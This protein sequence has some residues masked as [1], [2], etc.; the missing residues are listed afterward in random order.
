MLKISPTSEH[1][2]IGFRVRELI[3]SKPIE[4]NW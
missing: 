2:L 3:I 4:N 1:N